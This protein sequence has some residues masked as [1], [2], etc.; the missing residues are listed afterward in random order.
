MMD[1]D[2]ATLGLEF[3]GGAT[4]GFIAGYVAKKA[5]KLVAVVVG[6]QLALLRY[7]E[8][9]GILAVDWN[10]LRAE[11]T[12]LGAYAD[13]GYLEGVVSTL[14]IGAGVTGGFLLGFRR[15]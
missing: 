13:P 14:S 11:I 7:L 6:L 5:T 12:A 3:G 10:E 15:G 4:A 2:P 8:H 1:L 9:E